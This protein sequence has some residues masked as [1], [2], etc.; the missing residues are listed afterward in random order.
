MDCS[1]PTAIMENIGN[2]TWGQVQYPGEIDRFQTMFDQKPFHYLDRVQRPS[3]L[4]ASV[5]IFDQ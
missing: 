4:L 1:Q 3:R 5:P 2:G